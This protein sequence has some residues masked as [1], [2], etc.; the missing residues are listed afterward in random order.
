MSKYIY[1]TIYEEFTGMKPPEPKQNKQKNKSYRRLSGH[2]YKS[3][4]A[5]YE[6]R[7]FKKKIF[8]NFQLSN[9]SQLNNSNYSPDY[10]SSDTELTMAKI[11]NNGF[12]TTTN[13]NLDSTNRMNPRHQNYNSAPVIKRLER[14]YYKPVH[15]NQP[16]M[17][18]EYD[19]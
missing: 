1:K 6:K 7:Y 15:N 8:S 13:H 18:G 5:S 14:K 19:F 9:S 17:Q 12:N 16:S 3:K 10:L 11:R 2:P 4:H